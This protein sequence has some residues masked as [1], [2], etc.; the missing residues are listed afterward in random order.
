MRE[1]RILYHGLGMAGKTTNLEKLKEIYK[2]RVYDR[3]HQQTA[4]GRTVYLDLL[5]LK[6]HTCVQGVDVIVS[7]FTTPGQKRF[8]VLRP[9]LFGHTSSVVF[10]FDSSRDIQE[11]M[12][13]FY[14]IKDIISINRI[15]VQAN[16]RD[17]PNAVPLEIIKETFNSM[18][19]IPAV[20]K[21]GIGV[22]ETLKEAIKTALKN[23]EGAVRSS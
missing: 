20:A 15:V 16:K 3:I 9:W 1:L 17:V 10:V 7:L 5:M 14:E 12:E 4:E 22:L 21:D 13:S 11:N 18:P 2:D 23:E 19:V 6:F 8:K